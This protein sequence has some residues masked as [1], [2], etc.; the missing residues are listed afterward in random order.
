MFLT[1]MWSMDSRKVL[2][3][4]SIAST[5]FWWVVESFIWTLVLLTCWPHP[6]VDLVKSSNGTNDYASK[7]TLLIA[8]SGQ[9]PCDY[10]PDIH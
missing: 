7:Q 1:W 3:P 5:K 9:N 8:L 6:L 10:I 2:K 4:F